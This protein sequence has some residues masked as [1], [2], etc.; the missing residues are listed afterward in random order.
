MPMIPELA[1]INPKMWRTVIMFSHQ[2]RRF[3]FFARCIANLLV[4]PD[5]ALLRLVRIF[6]KNYLPHHTIIAHILIKVKHFQTILP[7]L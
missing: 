6:A 5:P 1:L 4:L 3:R 7:M 2:R